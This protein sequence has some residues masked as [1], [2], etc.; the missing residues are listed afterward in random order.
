VAYG[1]IF[2]VPQWGTVVWGGIPDAI[3]P[4]VNLD[5][6]NSLFDVWYRL[7]FH[8]FSD[9]Q[10]SVWASSSEL[11]QFAD[12]ELKALA[13]R[14][15]IFI[16]TDTS[17]TATAATAV[18]N[19]PAGHVFSVFAW[20]AYSAPASL[21]IL[22][23]SAVREL[24]SLDADWPAATGDP[25]RISLD[26]G[27]VGTATLYPN[28]VRQATLGQVLQT[29]PAGPLVPVS[30]ILQDVFSYS[31]LAGARAKESDY[32]VDDMAAHYAERVRLYEIVATYLWGDGR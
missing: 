8:D 19:L 1:S 17:I 3:A 15:A 16:T 14:T 32:R 28:P 10:N 24:E 11:Y 27:K 23:S 4:P 5:L 12:D 20:L 2:G 30:L 13:Y 7:G 6:N 25:E 26:A 21:R 9:M 22:R 31:M 18:Y 29:V